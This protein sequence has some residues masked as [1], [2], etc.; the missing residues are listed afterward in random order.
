MTLLIYFH[1]QVCSQDVVIYLKYMTREQVRDDACTHLYSLQQRECTDKFA[2]NNI[3]LNMDNKRNNVQ[4]R[5]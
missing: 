5:A 1:F 2:L 3:R 4:E